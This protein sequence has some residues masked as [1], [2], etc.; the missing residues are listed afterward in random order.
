MSVKP[1]TRRVLLVEDNAVNALVTEKM[2]QTVESP[3]FEVVR[4]GSLVK[5]LEL[6]ARERFDAALVDLNLPDS[7]GLD[8]FLAI[9]RAAPGLAIVVLSGLESDEVAMRAVELGAQDYLS[10]SQLAAPDLARTLN[11]SVI[12]SRKQAAGQPDRPAATVVGFLG[13]KGGVGTTTLACHVARELKRQTN[14]SVLLTGLDAGT[15]GIGYLMK[16]QR[17]YTL[18]DPSENLHRLDAELW[19]GLVSTT[20]DG[21]D[22]LPPPGAAAFHGTLEAER[23]RH[24]LRFAS[25]LYGHVVLDLGVLSA[26]SLP[27]LEDTNRLCIV[28]SEDL[29][30]LWEAGRLM[31][32]LGQLGFQAERLSFVVNLK[33]RRGG[34]STSELE[35]ALGQPVFAAIHEAREEVDDFL[36]EGRF[37]DVKSTLHKDTIKLVARMLG[38]DAPEPKPS[39]FSLSRLVS[40]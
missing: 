20:D 14:E 39:G 37:I 24:V 6:A 28:A 12:R 22:L 33:K 23:I 30:S 40:K 25:K 11:Y 15:A 29:L 5:A 27:L 3:R 35:K 38:K 18:A 17:Q 7:H 26:L 34:L 21:V 36:A 9:Q 2:L 16:A 1:E 32:R 4:A 10:K 31:T 19:K 8:T 13:S